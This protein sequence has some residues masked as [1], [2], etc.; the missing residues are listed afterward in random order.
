MLQIL[1]E[2]TLGVWE[3]ASGFRECFPDARHHTA[4]YQKRTRFVSQVT[5]FH[6]ESKRRESRSRSISAI[7]YPAGTIAGFTQKNVG[8]L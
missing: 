1:T 3:P 4:S 5:R 7:P 2:R 6:A 8:I